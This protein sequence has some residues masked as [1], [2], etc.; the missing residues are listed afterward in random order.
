[1]ASSHTNHHS[2]GKGL[3]SLFTSLFP[4]K[5]KNTEIDHQIS[6][7]A[8]RLGDLKTSELEARY[9]KVEGTIRIHNIN[10]IN[11][12]KENHFRNLT[13]S[14]KHRTL[15]NLF[16]SHASASTQ[17]NFQLIQPQSRNARQF[18][19]LAIL[20]FIKQKDKYIF[21]KNFAIYKRTAPNYKP[22]ISMATPKKT[23]VTGTNLRQTTSKSE[24][25]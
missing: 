20:T 22:N 19:A 25:A 11:E 1:M 17:L 8:V 2:H 5:Q 9:H 15:N 13:A 12:G 3:Y 24:L 4:K 18:K 16:Q 10:F 21:E 14:E 7:L 6:K 23:Q